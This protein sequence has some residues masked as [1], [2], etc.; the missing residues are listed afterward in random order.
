M[1]FET[2]HIFVDTNILV[3]IVYIITLHR[4]LNKPKVKILDLLENK[5]LVVYTDSAIIRELKNVALPNLLSNVDRAKHGWP[6]VEVNA[7]EQYCINQLNDMVSKRYIR[8]VEDDE[9]LEIQREALEHRP[10]RRV[11]WKSEIMDQ[12]LSKIPSEDIDI[13]N[14]LLYAYDLL[15]TVPRR[16]GP[17]ITSGKLDFITEDKNLRDFVEKHL[18][19]NECPCAN[20]IITSNYREFKEQLKRI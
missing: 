18:A 14:S 13:V 20:K 2:F 3:N 4:K 17:G 16:K 11:C 7:M 8:V 6:N 1:V 9:S 15:A 19:C 12:L 5:I 10:K